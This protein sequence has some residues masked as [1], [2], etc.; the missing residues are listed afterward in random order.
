MPRTVRGGKPA[1]PHAQS[2]YAKKSRDEVDEFNLFQFK[3]GLS[4][5]GIFCRWFVLKWKCGGKDQR[6][7]HDTLLNRRTAD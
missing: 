5:P 7:S 4:D 2:D 6:K 3:F 1:L